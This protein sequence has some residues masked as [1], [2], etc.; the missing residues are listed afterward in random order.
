LIEK[1]T[2]FLI[3][4]QKPISFI[5]VDNKITDESF[6]DSTV[7]DHY[8]NVGLDN[9]ALLSII[10]HFYWNVILSGITLMK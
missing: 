10:N 6:Q 3:G 5:L 1:N 2:I 9:N 8:V 4:T 7:F